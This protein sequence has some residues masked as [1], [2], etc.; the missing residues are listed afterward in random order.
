MVTP[1]I[2]YSLYTFN[3]IAT[4][5]GEL[6]S[7][8]EE[9]H[10]GMKDNFTLPE[11]FKYATLPDIDIRH[12]V[13]KLP[14]Q[15]GSNFCNYLREVQEA[16]RAHL[17]ECDIKE[18][19]FLRALISYI[20]DKKLAVHIWGRHTQ[21]TETVDWDSPKG[22]VSRFIRMSQDRTNY[23][24]SLI[25]IQVKGITNLEASAEVTCSESG[26]VIGHLSL[27]QTLLK[28]LKLQDG[29]PMCAE[30]H[31]CGPKGPVDMV[32]PNTSLAECCFEMFNK[33]L[34]G[35]LYHVPPTSGTSNLFIKTLLRQSMDARLTIEAPLCTY[36]P[37]THVLTT[38]CDLVQEGVLSNVHSLPF[39]QDVLANKL[40]VDASKKSKKV[41][42]APKMC[43]QLGSAC[44]VQT[45]H[46]ENDG[47]HN[48][49]PEPGVNLCLATKASAANPLNANQ[50]VI[51]IASSE[52]DASSNDGSEGSSNDLS[53]SDSLSASSSSDEEERSVAPA[54]D[55]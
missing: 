46:G 14:G 47:K 13:P 4:L 43:F 53:S 9:A 55:G 27:H 19:P 50:P 42:T 22:H 6:T 29:N 20:K 38:P 49:V 21:I 37:T 48:N 7:L 45:V 15:P 40:A 39:F 3:N 36:D 12:G 31:Q 34:A 1:F 32:I 11:E 10:Q 28:Y 33:Q 5:W 17:I 26:N 52:D 23:N 2:I 44:S 41:Y 18:I 51:K 35:Y 30:L 8:L 16:R 25:S 54:G 24:M